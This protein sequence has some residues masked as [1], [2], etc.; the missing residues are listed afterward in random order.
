[1]RT[2]MR[3]SDGTRWSNGRRCTQDGFKYSHPNR[4]SSGLGNYHGSIGPVYE[5]KAD[6]NVLKKDEAPEKPKHEA[7]Q[8]QTQPSKKGSYG[9]PQTTFGVPQ[10]APGVNTGKIGSEYEHLTE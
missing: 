7:R 6:F 2:H 3:P 8:M 1:M 9:I 10:L 4:K 5:H